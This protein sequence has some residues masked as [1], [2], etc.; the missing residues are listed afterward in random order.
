[1]RPIA[2][3]TALEVAT[4]CK[5]AA[6]ELRGAASFEAAADSFA[7]QLVREFETI[8][9]ARVFGTVEF[10]ALPP[11]E[12]SFAESTVPDLALFPKTEVLTLFGTAGTKPDW[13]DRRTSAGHLA[14]PLLNRRTIEEAPM[15]TRL[16]DDLRF[17]LKAEAG[18]SRQ[19]ATRAFADANAVCYIPDAATT[20]DVLGRLVIPATEFVRDNTIRTVV[21]VGGSYVVARM[22]V[23]ILLF[24]TEAI[25]PAT[26][27]HLKELSNTFKVAT[28]GLVRRKSLFGRDA[29]EDVGRDLSGF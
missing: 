4:F 28:T 16:L 29:A 22:F 8:A 25:P 6:D 3:L 15:I 19:L 11:A 27:I 2:D 14:I 17:S 18:D 26:A 13:N 20:V 21:G 10:E 23:A 1:M 12:R 24:T 7:R 9:L 5:R